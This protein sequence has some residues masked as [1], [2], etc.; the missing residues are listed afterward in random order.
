MI[1]SFFE[2]GGEIFIGVFGS[3][4]KFYS[5]VFDVVKYSFKSPWRFKLLADQMH[6]IGVQSIPIVFL[7]SLAIGM[8]FALQFT[9]VLRL[10]RA[11]ILVGSSVAMTFGR[12]LAPVVTALMLIAKNGSAM[13][14]ELGTMKVTEQI[15]AMETMSVN[16]IH[17]LVVPKVFASLIV[18]PVL[19]GLSNV[20]GVAGAYF[21]SVI[22]LDVD[23]GA[24]L[25]KMYWYTNPEDIWTGILKAAFL[26]VIVAV[27]SSY[28]GLMTKNGAKGVG[29]ST[30]KAVVYSSVTI[31]LADYVLT[32]FMIK[33][34]YRQY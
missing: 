24:Y 5:Y 9:H 18:F 12:E 23:P 7:S 13:A 2:K 8:I 16:P 22:L 30:T 10:F 4:G 20:I 27:I 33:L 15:D 19:A 11:E 29:E 25:Q 1:I 3:L 14:A 32:D 31:L 28:H 26:G 17:Y 6:K 21:V 34:F